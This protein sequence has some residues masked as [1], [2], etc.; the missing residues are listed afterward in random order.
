MA[1][2]NLFSKITKLAKHLKYNSSL[3]KFN[4]LIDWEIFRDDLEP[5]V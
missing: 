2:I 1:Q 5:N 3:Q 4:D